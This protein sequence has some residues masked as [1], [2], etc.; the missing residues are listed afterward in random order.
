MALQVGIW[1]SPLRILNSKQARLT[2]ENIV[3]QVLHSTDK[4]SLEPLSTTHEVVTPWEGC[5]HLSSLHLI[6]CETML[7]YPPFN[8]F[9]LCRPTFLMRHSGYSGGTVLFVH[10]TLK[11]IA[12]NCFLQISSLQCDYC[13]ATLTLMVAGRKASGAP[14]GLPQCICLPTEPQSQKPGKKIKK[15]GS[16]QTWSDGNIWFLKCNIN[17]SYCWVWSYNVARFYISF[18]YI[19]KKSI[20]LSIY[21]MLL[22]IMFYQKENSHESSK[23]KINDIFLESWAGKTA[24][25]GVLPLE[26][27]CSLLSFVYWTQFSFL[28]QWM[29]AIWNIPI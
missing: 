29:Y 6:Q 23:V 9:Q 10:L 8:P 16:N 7:E 14:Q 2:L 28:T 4:P 19:I 22:L 18:L 15:P 27:C 17:M 1:I 20:Y 12:V 25:A 3:F 5:K 21:Y 24:N 11:W 13:S 26:N